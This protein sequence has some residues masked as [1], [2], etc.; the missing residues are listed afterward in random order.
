[1]WRVCESYEAPFIN[2][3]K[4]KDR[5]EVKVEGAGR[6]RKVKVAGLVAEGFVVNTAK[7]KTHADT[8][9]TLSLK[10]M[11]GVLLDKFK[12]KYHLMGFD[13]VIVDVNVAVR[14]ALCVIDAS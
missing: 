11:L 1:M 8:V 9:V 13:D 7:I 3:S 4:V 2:L 14:P 10:N 12:A 6:L 5:V